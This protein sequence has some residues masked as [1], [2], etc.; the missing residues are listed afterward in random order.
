MPERSLLSESPTPA[1]NLVAKGKDRASSAA[2]FFAH[3]AYKIA[4]GT[5]CA[6]I[7]FAYINVPIGSF[8][9]VS[10]RLSGLST[11]SAGFGTATYFACIIAP[12]SLSLLVILAIVTASS[13][14]CDQIIRT[15]Y[16]PIIAMM[17][18]NLVIVAGYIVFRG[19]GANDMFIALALTFGH[20][21]GAAIVG[22]IACV[23]TIAIIK[24]SNAKVR[25]AR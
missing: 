20:F 2:A 7:I 18:V 11:I 8:E 4:A 22:A 15:A 23:I 14:A 17:I 25:A 6:I 5:L 21:I 19:S 13:N 12:I 3:N 9:Q 16:F 24:L 10:S 1:A